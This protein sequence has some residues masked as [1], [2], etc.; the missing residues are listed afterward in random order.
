MLNNVV[1]LL[2]LILLVVLAGCGTPTPP[3][4]PTAT[5]TVTHTPSPTLTPSP[6]P[7]ATPIPPIQLMVDWPAEVS[8]L[9]PAFVEVDVVPPPGVPADP[10]VSAEVFDPEGYVYV[11][12]NLYPRTPPRYVSTEPLRL[13]LLPLEGEWRLVV[14]VAS[15][16]EVEG[17]TEITFL[18]APVPFRDLTGVPEQ[19]SLRVPETFV[20]VGEGDVQAGWRIWRYEEEQLELWW[21]PGP[22]EPLAFNTAVVFLE[23]TY[24][25][26]EPDVETREET[27]WDEQPAFVFAETWHGSGAGEGEAWVIQGPEQWLYV[28]RLRSMDEDGIS[29]LLRQVAE[30]LTF[31]VEE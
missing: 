18:P 30:T 29:S 25:G 10:G 26:I 3:P 15:P 16:L 5:P 1:R 14:K 24:L 8:A 7:T 27:T 6:T 28:L 21:A 23:S 20:E 11:T 13:P 12:F 19:V 31:P 22:A 9:E 4:T 17:D 2:L